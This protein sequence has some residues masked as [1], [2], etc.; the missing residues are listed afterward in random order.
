MGPRLLRT[1][2]LGA[3]IV[4]AS[5]AS[6][7]E[8]VENKPSERA[9]STGFLAEGG[10]GAVAFTPKVGKDAAPGPEIEL[11]LGR[12]LLSWLSLDAFGAASMHQATLPPPPDGQYFQ[13]YRFG[14]DARVNLRFNA[15]S[16]FIE[17]GAGAAMMSSNVLE[18]VMITKP[19]QQL[20]IQFHGGFGLEYQLENRHFGVGLG[21]D[22]F[23]APQ[24]AEM[25]A[26]ASRLYL[27]YTYGGG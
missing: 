21:V 5:A 3:A 27:R 9:A 6:A 22:G 24:F 15:V 18:P 4:V 2:A 7:D 13:L 25:K 23:L 11:R 16:I 8:L 19:G 20:S 1:F 17:G 26:I 10:L 12:D 14:G